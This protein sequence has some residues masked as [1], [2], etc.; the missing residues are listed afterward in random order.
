MLQ[1]LPFGTNQLIYDFSPFPFNFTK[2]L[3]RPRI[4][5][6]QVPLTPAFTLVTVSICNLM[7]GKIKGAY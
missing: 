1:I 5:K 2:P 6:V 7:C 4:I 3:I